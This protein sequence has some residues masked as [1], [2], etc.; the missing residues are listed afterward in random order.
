MST[1][2]VDRTD[3][4]RAR[5]MA[6]RRLSDAAIRDLAEEMCVPEE[7]FR[8]VIERYP[9]LNRVLARRYRAATCTA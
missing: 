6:A 8:A 1:A 5:H 7:L 2:T 4:P 9:D 3:S